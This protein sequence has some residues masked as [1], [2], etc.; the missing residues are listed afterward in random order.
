MSLL[1]KTHNS[2]ALYRLPKISKRPSVSPVK[3]DVAKVSQNALN[4]KYENMHGDYLNT[5]V[6]NDLI[7]NE[8]MHSVSVFKD[9]LILDDVN[10]FLKRPYAHHEQKP[11]ITRL[12]DFYSEYSQLFP[13]Y[14]AL[15]PK[16]ANH[17]FKNIQRK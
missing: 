4:K 3:I 16:P 11:R 8:P 1:A 14:I 15:M 10:E 7:Y 5:K 12:C 2:P 13:N 17:L 6:I 9:Y